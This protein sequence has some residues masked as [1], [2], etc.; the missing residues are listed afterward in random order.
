LEDVE[1]DEEFV[2]DRYVGFGRRYR[3]IPVVGSKLVVRLNGAGKVAIVSGECRRIEQEMAF[4]ACAVDTPIA[5]LILTDAGVNGR[6]RDGS[7]LKT[8]NIAGQ[9]CGYLEAPADHRQL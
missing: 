1:V 2:S 4:Q 9:N 8:I 6:L 7:S 5:D 3:G